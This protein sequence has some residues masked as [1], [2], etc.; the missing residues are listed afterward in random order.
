MI[1]RILHRFVWDCWSFVPKKPSTTRPH[2]FTS[3][4]LTSVQHHWVYC[5]SN[6]HHRSQSSHD[7]GHLR[8]TVPG[9]HTKNKHAHTFKWQS[10]TSPEPSFTSKSIVGL[11]TASLDSPAALPLVYIVSFPQTLFFYNAPAGHKQQKT[12]VCLLFFLTSSSKS[13]QYD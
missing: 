2:T 9:R 12:L 8:A 7:A 10:A 3:S 11:R 4:H 1:F 13:Y 5:Y 6:S